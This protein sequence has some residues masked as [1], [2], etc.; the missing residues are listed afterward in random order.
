MA[1]SSPYRSHPLFVPRIILLSNT[2]SAAAAAIAIAYVSY[3]AFRSIWTVYLLLFFLSAFAVYYD[4]AEWAIHKSHDS[5]STPPV[6]NFSLLG[7]F[8]FATTFIAL[9]VFQLVNIRGHF[10]RYHGPALIIWASIPTLISVLVHSY[11]FGKQ[12]ERTG[13]GSSLP[14]GR[15]TGHIRIEGEGPAIS[16]VDADA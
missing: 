5:E 3:A 1:D 8:M 9:Y 15:K 11:C 16:T 12:L 14:W 6:S 13:Y 4:L 10:H 2:I 7:D